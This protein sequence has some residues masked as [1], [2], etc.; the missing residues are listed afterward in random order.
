MCMA[1]CWQEKKIL[2]PCSWISQLFCVICC[3]GN[4]TWVETMILWATNPLKVRS[5]GNRLDY[6]RMKKLFSPPTAWRRP[7]SYYANIRDVVLHS[8][9][10]CQLSSKDHQSDVSQDALRFAKGARHSRIRLQRANPSGYDISTLLLRAFDISIYLYLSLSISIFFYSSLEIYK[11][12][13]SDSLCK[14]VY[15]SAPLKL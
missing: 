5:C 6:E 10:R 12:L 13:I 8:S 15:G 2:T 11:A 9:S 14:T 3:Y 1:L 4:A 7:A